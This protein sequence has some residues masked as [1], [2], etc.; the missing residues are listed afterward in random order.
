MVSSSLISQRLH[1]ILGWPPSSSTDLYDNPEPAFQKGNAI[2]FGFGHTVGNVLSGWTRVTASLSL[3]FALF[4]AC[5]LLDWVCTYKHPLNPSSISWALQQPHPDKHLT[6]IPW[7]LSHPLSDPEVTGRT[8]PESQILV[9]ATRE[10]ASWKKKKGSSG[11]VHFIMVMVNTKLL[12]LKGK[13]LPISHPLGSILLP[14]T[15]VLMQGRYSCSFMEWRKP[16][17]TLRTSPPQKTQKPTQKAV[18]QTH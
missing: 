15:C 12:V 14:S 11:C 17:F 2:G 7:E 13:T 1:L 6:Q 10:E 3:T 8:G 5:K 16:H 18:G 9:M 4:G